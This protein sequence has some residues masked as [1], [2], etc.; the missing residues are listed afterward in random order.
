VERQLHG[1]WLG[2]RDYDEVHRLQQG[3]QAARIAGSA[4]DTVLFVEH[5]PV[6]TLGRGG[7]AENLLLSSD[8]LRA[9]GVQ[10]VETGRGGDVTLHAPGQLVMYPIVDLSPERKDV[11]RYVGD[12]TETMR[13]LALDHG[14][15]G[16]PVPDLIGLWVN[17]DDPTE[18]TGRGRLAKL[19]AI[20]VRISRWVTMHGLAFNLRTELGQFAWIV[21]CGIREYGVTSVLELTGSAPEVASVVPRAF[22]LFADVIGGSVVGIE[23]RSTRP[24]TPSPSG[25]LEANPR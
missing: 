21:P 20:G 12:L 25:N 15:A 22:E 16:G 13:R 18:W 23:D 11:R 9:R 3:L 17:A 24:L 14:I 19:G 1:I 7:K 5:E 4:P 8:A 2:R 10:V 6:I